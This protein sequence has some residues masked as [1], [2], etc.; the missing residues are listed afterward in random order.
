[1]SEISQFLISAEIFV[2]K[3]LSNQGSGGDAGILA[4]INWAV[5]N[6]CQVISMS[7]GAPVQPGEPFSPVYEGVAQRALTSGTL[8]VAAAG[9]DS[10]RPGFIMPVAR[11]ANCPSIL[12]VAAVDVNMQ[13]AFFSNRGI[14]PNGGQVDIA[15]P[16]VN[17]R[18]TWPMPRRY[19]TISGTSMA[20]PHVAGI[21]ALLRETQSIPAAQLWTKLT[22]SARRLNLASVDVGA[23]L[24]QA[25]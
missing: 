25:P 1:M 12:A 22:Q 8:I 10:R 9:N 19:H 13:I 2:G 24:V 3:V 16:G 7:L 6:G 18:S 5:A 11:P 14:N 17:V 23:G 15:G 20:T 4:G 21:A